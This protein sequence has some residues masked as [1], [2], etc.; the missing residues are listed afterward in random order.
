MAG[1]GE[2]CSVSRADGTYEIAGLTLGGYKV[3]F[4]LAPYVTQYFDGAAT[5]AEAEAVTVMAG[6]VSGG[7][8][9]TMVQPEIPRNIT[10]PE[11]IGVGKAGESL[12]CTDG[13]WRRLPADVLL[14]VLMVPR[15]QPD[16]GRR[17]GRLHL[18]G[19]RRGPFDR[20]RRDRDEL[21]GTAASVQSSNSIAVAAIRQVKLFPGGN[22]FGS[23][24]V[25]PQ[26][27]TCATQCDVD[28]N[29][30]ETVTITASPATHY[31]FTGWSGAGYG[32]RFLRSDAGVHLR[33]RPGQL[34]P[35]HP[36]GLGD[37]RR[38]RLG[39][40][41]GRRHL[42]LHRNRWDLPGA[43]EEGGYAFLTPTPA[44]HYELTGWTGCAREI[45][46]ECWVSTEAAA[47]VTAT[48]APIVRRLEVAMS[49]NG[50]GTVVSSPTGID[51]GPEC[52]MSAL[53]GETVTLT[54]SP[55][56]HSEFT[57]WSGGLH[58]CRFVEVTLGSRPGRH[59][60]LH[61]DHPPG[62]GD[63]HRL[64]FGRRLRKRPPR[65]P[66]VGRHLFRGI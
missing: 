43:Y 56:S 52:S 42:R 35:D 11:A 47:Q 38:P 58:G 46:G 3:R 19:R 51:C 34:G 55:V 64:R 28:A 40:R 65:L 1:G 31:E 32:R 8:D 16:R 9:A 10:P 29:E 5:A 63:R 49:G 44:P 17:N 15:R 26:G 20:L 22:G 61:R 48:F 45:G 30:G 14:R 54:A 6:Q 53:D 27:I 21:L 7:V 4:S 2:E 23:V 37:C 33:A 13:T 25:S 39:Q 12:S 60:Q 41:L 59:R 50:S 62:V 66:S 18:D 57:G 36:S 24:T